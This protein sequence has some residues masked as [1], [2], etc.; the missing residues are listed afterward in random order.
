MFNESVYSL[1]FVFAPGPCPFSL[2]AMQVIGIR[3]S[4]DISLHGSFVITIVVP[5]CGIQHL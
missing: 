4:M 5:S 2:D 1:Y 3:E